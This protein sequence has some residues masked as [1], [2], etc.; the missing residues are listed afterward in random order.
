MVWCPVT[1]PSGTQATAICAR[2]GSIDRGHF[3]SA[4]LH[5]PRYSAST[6]R[7]SFIAW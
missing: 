1:D 3:T 7:D 2:A 6:P 4:S 5:V